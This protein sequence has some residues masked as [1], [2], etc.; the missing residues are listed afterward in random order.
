MTATGKA[1]VM[2]DGGF[3]IKALLIQAGKNR[4][5]E[6]AIDYAALTD[7]LAELAED[8]TSSVVLR[9][10]W[11]DAA[12]AARPRAEHRALAAVPGVHVR[13]GWMIDTDRGPQ[14]KAVD[15][16]IVRDIVIA[17]LNHVA[18]DLILIAG[19]GDLVPGLREAVDRGLRVH[20]W[21][22]SLEDPRVKQS[23]ELIA[24]ADR[25]LTL[26]LADFAP[27]V[28]SRDQSPT[29]SDA[30]DDVPSP[31]SEFSETLRTATANVVLDLELSQVSAA[32][33]DPAEEVTTEGHVLHSSSPLQGV[34]NARMGPPPLHILSA[35]RQG[36]QDLAEDL[37]APLDA[38]GLGARYGGRWWTRASGDVRERLLTV[39]WRPGLPRLLDSD[40]IRYARARGINPD[41]ELYRHD[42]RVGF[43]R[44]ADAARSETLASG[45]LD[46]PVGRQEIDH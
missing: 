15:T 12:R 6:V 41:A 23:E 20:L 5:E 24:L 39:A 7:A 22:V 3:L 21:G 18:D 4:R 42:L 43:W 10:T 27:H 36:E 29:R 33:V 2:V 1:I 44:G 19:D 26:D 17:A 13:L 37:E 14:Q 25:R 28:R 46:P 30:M 31:T 16:T 32:T 34:A 35:V 45:V 11:Y 40:L 8:E 38:Q 9:Q